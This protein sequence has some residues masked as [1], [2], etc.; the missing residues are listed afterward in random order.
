MLVFGEFECELILT[1]SLFVL[2]VYLVVW[3]FSEFVRCSPQLVGVGSEVGELLGPPSFRLQCDFH[4]WDYRLYG[5]LQSFHEFLT[6]HLQ[7]CL[8]IDTC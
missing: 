6:S 5:F 3:D 4:C 8:V 2:L 7:L 1:F